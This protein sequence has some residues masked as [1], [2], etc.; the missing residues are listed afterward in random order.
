MILSQ[1]NDFSVV[2]HDML[3]IERLDGKGIPRLIMK[4]FANKKC[5]CA[6]IVLMIFS[7]V[8]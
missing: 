5:K 2:D 7:L 6:N 8:N 1:N 4:M 3:T